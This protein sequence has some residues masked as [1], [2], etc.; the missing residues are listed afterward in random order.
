MFLASFDSNALSPNS[1]KSDCINSS[2]SPNK[3][4]SLYN[5]EVIDEDWGFLLVE[6]LTYAPWSRE[7]SLFVDRAIAA[8][9]GGEANG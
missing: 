5:L 6:G 3:V 4:Q 7:A 9:E 1:D 2:T 8:R